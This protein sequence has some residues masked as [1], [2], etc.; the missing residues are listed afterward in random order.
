MT[1]AP[2]AYAVFGAQLGIVCEND[3][4]DVKHRTNATPRMTAESFFIGGAP[5]LSS[6]SSCWTGCICHGVFQ[7]NGLL[8]PVD[9]VFS[10]RLELC[11]ALAEDARKNSNT[12]HC[13]D[14]TIQ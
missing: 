7:Q 8:E 3:A 5:S 11:A 6:S 12:V 4:T 10:T 13:F 2:T 1:S 14:E 9:L